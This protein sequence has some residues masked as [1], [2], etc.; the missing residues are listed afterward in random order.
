MLRLVVNRPV[1]PTLGEEVFSVDVGFGVEDFELDAFVED[2]E[3]L[4]FLTISLFCLLALYAIIPTIK[5]TNNKPPMTIISGLF[6][7]FETIGG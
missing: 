3:G 1:R 2:G 4:G 6:A 5:I 7:P